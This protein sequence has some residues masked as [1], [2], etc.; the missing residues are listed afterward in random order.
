MPLFRSARDNLLNLAGL[1]CINA[2]EPFTLVQP[3]IKPLPAAVIS[4]DSL[5]HESKLPDAIA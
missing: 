5:S 1:L 4:A 3:P 2:I